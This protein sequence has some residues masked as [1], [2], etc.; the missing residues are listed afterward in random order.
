MFL[1]A[2]NKLVMGNPLDDKTDIGPLVNDAAAK[3]PEQ[4]QVGRIT[5]AF[6]DL[7]RGTEMRLLDR[8]ESRLHRMVQRTL[9]NIQLLRQLEPSDDSS[10]ELTKL[11]WDSKIHELP[12]EPDSQQNLAEAAPEVPSPVAQN[13]LLALWRTLDRLCC[14]FLPFPRDRHDANFTDC[15]DRMLDAAR[16]NPSQGAR[17]G[18]ADHW[19]CGLS[20]GNRRRRTIHRSAGDRSLV[21]VGRIPRV[22]APRSSLTGHIDHEFD[23]VAGTAR[24]ARCR[25]RP[26]RRRGAEGR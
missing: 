25:R 8:Y 17:N 26:D 24:P 7:S 3:R 18:V 11:P 19:A 6:S 4:T 12:N 20:G 5:G 13:S 10:G 9:K 21:L 23:R 15:V 22:V 2:T 16:R 14:P 1:D